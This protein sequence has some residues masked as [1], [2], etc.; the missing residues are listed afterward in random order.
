MLALLPTPEKAAK[1]VLQTRQSQPQIIHLETHR[2]TMLDTASFSPNRFFIVNVVRAVTPGVYH[3]L[4]RAS[5]VFA[6][7]NHQMR[8]V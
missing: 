2:S 1:L 8:A 6:L 3:D 4:T 5:G 7:Y